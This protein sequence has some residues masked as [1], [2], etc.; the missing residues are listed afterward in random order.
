MKTTSLDNIQKIN[1][2]MLAYSMITNSG[3][4][5]GKLKGPLDDPFIGLYY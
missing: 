2:I 3:Q 4:S 5:G 1:Q